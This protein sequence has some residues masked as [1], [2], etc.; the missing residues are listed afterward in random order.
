MDMIHRIISHTDLDM[1]TLKSVNGMKISTFW[2][3]DY[4]EMYHMRE[5]MTIMETP[6][7]IPN[8]IATSREILKNWVKSQL[9]LG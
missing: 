2:V 1:M 8:Y 6:F 3:H 7:S 4:D 5:P 9:D